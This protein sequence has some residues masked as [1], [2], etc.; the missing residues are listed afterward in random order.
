VAN[1]K[2]SEGRKEVRETTIKEERNAGWKE[3][4]KEERKKDRRRDRRV[5]R[6]I[7]LK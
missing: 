2:Y 6:R 1:E 3:G 7:I 5:V 4:R